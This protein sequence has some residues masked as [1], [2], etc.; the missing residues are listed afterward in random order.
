MWLLVLLLSQ[1][2]PPERYVLV[3]GDPL[4]P[5]PFPVHVVAPAFPDELASTIKVITVVI[6]A[7]IGSDGLVHKAAVSAGKSLKAQ[8]AALRVTPQW[9]FQ[10][11]KA[12]SAGRPVKLV[13]VFRTMPLG[14]PP[15]EIT[16]IFRDKYEVEVRRLR[17]PSAVGR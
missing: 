9:R 13:F 4:P 11:A 3:K 7:E 2:I 5:G 6:E 14:T 15:D 12:E 16:T 8:E 1:V 17:P 10:W